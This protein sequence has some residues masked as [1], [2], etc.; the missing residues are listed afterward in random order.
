[1]QF[2]NVLTFWIRK[3]YIRSPFVQV[4]KKFHRVFLAT[5]LTASQHFT[6]ALVPQQRGAVESSD[7]QLFVPPDL[8][9]SFSYCTHHL[10]LSAFKSLSFRHS[11]LSVHPSPLSFAHFFDPLLKSSSISHFSLSVV[12]IFFH[13]SNFLI[14]WFFSFSASFSL[15]LSFFSS[16]YLH[17]FPPFIFR[18]FYHFTMLPMR[19]EQL[20]SARR[21]NLRWQ[22]F[23]P[24]KR[25]T[26]FEPIS[27]LWQVPTGH[28]SEHFMTLGI[29]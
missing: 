12:Y 19:Y 16:F 26:Y 28:S 17:R 8:F 3:W 1:M 25:C 11:A 10:A 23:P 9:A 18:Y 7:A 15:N 20:Y 5:L 24:R 21:R 4:L 14:F 22:N 2:C 13:L 6:H 27:C 29:Q